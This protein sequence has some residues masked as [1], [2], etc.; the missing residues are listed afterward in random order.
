MQRENFERAN[1]ALQEPLREQHSAR[2]ERPL[3]SYAAAL[4]NRL[5]ID[6][7]AQTL[8]TP[9][10]LGR[11]VLDDVPLAESGALHR[12]DV[13][14]CGLGAQRA[15]SGDSRSPAIRR[16]GARVVRQRA[17]AARSDHRRETAGRPCRLRILAGGF[18]RRRH[19][20]VRRQSA[21]RRADA[22]Q[23]AAAAGTAAGRRAESV[24]RRFRRRPIGARRSITSA[25]SP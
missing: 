11:R 13:L 10:F 4:E 12:L 3:L 22:V 23:H 8:P 15:V 16:R 21:S 6:W 17:R 24:A 7:A 2:R 18:R 25:R 14:L 1:R 5:K 19:R 20:R 9:A